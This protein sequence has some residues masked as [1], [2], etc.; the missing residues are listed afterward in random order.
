MA[1]PAVRAW[2]GRLP[3]RRHGAGQDDPGPVAAADPEAD[4]QAR[5]KPSLLV[6]PASLLAN[7]AAEIERFAPDLNAKIVHPSAMTAG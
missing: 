3:R 7:W 5:R 6:A 2:A 1:P 4:E